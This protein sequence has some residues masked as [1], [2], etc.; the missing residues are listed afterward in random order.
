MTFIISLMAVGTIFAQG[1]DW[2]NPR[3]Q[4]TGAPSFTV[5]EATYLP[6]W[7]IYHIPT[8]AERSEI[9]NLAYS[10]QQVRNAYGKPMVIECWIRPTS[11]NPGKIDSSGRIVSDPNSQYKGRN[12]NREIAR[13][14]DGSEHVSGSAVDIKDPNKTLTDFLIANQKLLA[15]NGLWMENEVSTAGRVPANRWVHL[16]KKTSRGGEGGARYRIFKP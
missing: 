9:G 2:S 5:H 13:S 12:Y 3:A 4:I 11:V 1:M 15:D 14:S 8:Q 16:D 7:G 6:S 10:L